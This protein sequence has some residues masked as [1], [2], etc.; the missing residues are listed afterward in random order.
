MFATSQGYCFGLSRRTT[1][2]ISKDSTVD[3]LFAGDLG[4]T[5]L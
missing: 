1:I 2:D 4:A 3:L 5:S